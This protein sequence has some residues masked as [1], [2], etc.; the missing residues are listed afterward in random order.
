MG[1]NVNHIS[2]LGYS[3]FAHSVMKLSNSI[4]VE[5]ILNIEI[6]LNHLDANNETPIYNLLRNTN[7]VK[8]I[9]LISKLLKLTTNWDMQNMYGQSIIHLLV[10]R[11]DIEKF[12]N[13]LSTR[14][15]DINLKNKVGTSPIQILEI[16]LKN[17]KLKP[18]QIKDK[19]LKFKELVADNYINL[20]S[21]ESTTI[22]IPTNIKTNC[23][24]YSFK[25]NDPNRMKTSCW[26]STM[27]NLSKA[28][29]TDIDKL[30]KNYIDLIIDDYQFAH[31][32]LYN[33]RDS[34]IYIYYQ[35]LMNKHATLGI[36]LNDEKFD[37]KKALDISSFNPSNQEVLNNIE[38][39][40]SLLK[41]TLKYSM[42]Y[43]LNIYWINET[44]Y[45]IP[46]N[47]TNCVLNMIEL[48]KRFIICRINI[49]GDVLHANILLIDID[50]KRII[51]FEPQGGID[52]DNF[53]IL[54]KK[55]LDT[56]HKEKYFA[57]YIYFKPIDYE[58]INGLQS[59][60]QETN[61]LYI[62]KGDM[63]GFCLAWCMWWVEFYIENIHNELLSDKNLKLLIQ[64][65]IK[66]IINNGYL[67]SEYIRNY[68][69]Y[70]HQKLIINLSTNTLPLNVLYYEKYT[71]SEL[72]IIYSRINK[73]LLNIN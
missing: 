10:I 22:D 17:Q 20:F 36:P 15:F 50:N 52:K 70:M 7:C 61:N 48:G 55:I 54:D 27:K 34:D 29:L 21:D 11:P 60:S 59:I 72:D 71:N 9:D 26:I 5:Y 19:L 6:N 39:T 31:F 51:R 16:N 23:N 4:I 47:L 69:N 49:I 56:F 18:E 41:N 30:S 46:Y 62:R 14:Y 12:Y 44:N 58:P 68:A 32:N 24:N 43:P 3:N 42:L 8:S 65:V 40:Q 35:I 53:N 1:A 25:S 57:K 63:G 37:E 38:Y 33:A 45:I 67:L 73:D 64:K 2:P 66:R 28:S 13:I